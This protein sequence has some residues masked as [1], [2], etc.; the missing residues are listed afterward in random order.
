MSDTTSGTATR[1]M[2]PAAGVPRPYEFPH[3][4][5]F[6]L[7]NGLRVVVA[8]VH[9]LPLV[10]VSAVIDAGADGDADGREGL[11]ML[12]AAAL[13]EGTV[14]RDGPAL[15]DAFERLGTSLESGADWDEASAG[16]TVTPSRFDDAFALMAEVLMTP[17]FAEA[18][19]ERLKAERLAELLQQRVEPRGLADERFARA[20]YA[21]TSRYARPAGGTP[22]TVRA[23]DA[24]QVS[25]WHASRY[26]AATT[27]I[28]V[29]GDVSVEQVRA[30]VERR[31]G[32]WAGSVPLRSA[33]RV[34]PR[35]EARAVHVVAK[36]D[37]PQSELRVGHMGL[38]RLHEDYFA[39]VVM[40]AVLGGLFSSRINLNLREVHAYTYG[41]HSGFDWRRGAGPFVVGSAVKTEVTDAAVREILMEIDRIREAPVSADELDL[42]TKY[43][44]GVFPIRYETT[45]AVASA[46]AIATVYGLPDDYFS[47]YRDR[48]AAVTREDVLRVAQA[49][50]HPEALQI[51]AVGDADA[52]VAPLEALGVGAPTVPTAD[53][54][55]DA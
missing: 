2:R 21:S 49:H 18:D 5:R 54:G 3:A 41:A 12:A 10:S 20:V 16:F 32:A 6:T 42:A 27:T 29:A 11:A 53:E 46:L 28:I 45:G 31:L 37:A 30:V 40:N 13:A 26:A 51:L 24:S 33:V 34:E 15:A 47:T 36:A 48:I 19:V 1:A 55:E 22:K 50:L 43:L 4:T 35:T 23:L 9:R 7:S 17:R 8:P 52:I 44:G 38:P 39:V 25:V 14:E